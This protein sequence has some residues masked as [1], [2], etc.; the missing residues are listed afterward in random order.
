M[1]TSTTISTTIAAQYSVD[2]SKRT[3]THKTGD[4]L[5]SASKSIMLPENNNKIIIESLIELGL[6]SILNTFTKDLSPVDATELNSMLGTITNEQI[7]SAITEERVRG[8]KKSDYTTVQ[9]ISDFKTIVALCALA[10]F[11]VNAS[12]ELCTLSKATGV[13]AGTL[14]DLVNKIT[15]VA[16]AANNKGAF[17]EAVDAVTRFAGYLVEVIDIKEKLAQSLSKSEAIPDDVEI[18]FGE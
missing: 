5:V 16:T 7:I 9:R 12:V 8:A 2:V 18:T 11:P 6:K 17:P 4:A 3:K 10:K 13:S 15:K 1:T 14:I